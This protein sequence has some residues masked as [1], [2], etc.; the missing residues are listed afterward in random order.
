MS[1]AED[2][3]AEDRQAPV[4]LDSMGVKDDCTGQQERSPNSKWK[5]KSKKR[6]S[7]PSGEEIVSGSVEPLNPWKAGKY[8][9]PTILRL[10]TKIASTFTKH[11]QLQ[12]MRFESS[13]TFICMERCKVLE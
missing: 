4:Q 2:V 12:Q 13:P 1:A 3:H 8:S 6:V 7:F 9:T 10:S 5:I 11:L